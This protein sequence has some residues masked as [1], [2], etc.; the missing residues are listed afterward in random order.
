[1][2]AKVS[3]AILARGFIT[4]ADAKEDTAGDGADTGK[5]REDDSDTV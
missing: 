1:M 3:V 4:G 2:L 5:G